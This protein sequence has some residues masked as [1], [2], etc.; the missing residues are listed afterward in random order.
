[1]SKKVLKILEEQFGEAI[2]ETH[3]QFGDDTAV[4]EPSAWKSV[5]TFVR[6]D[7][8]AQM[9]HFIDL[10]AVDYLDRRSPR[11]EIVLHL[12]SISRAHRVRLK[13]RI[14]GEPPRI[15][16]LVDVWRGAD[17]FE[18]ECYDMFGVDFAGHPD[19]R[20]ILMYEE[21]EGHPLRKD[22][23]V[24]RAQPL[25]EYRAEAL[26]KLPPFGSSE[27]RPFGRQVHD[28]RPRRRSLLGGP[29]GGAASGDDAAAVDAVSEES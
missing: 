18:R 19:L 24:E 1:M 4:V 6:D 17:W 7:S 16:S 20:R 28:A 21:F 8:R 12:R 26:D 13:A 10:T 9:D 3:S 14:D 2:L 5:A 25:V 23:P 29:L 11:Y 27:G 22:Y 15:D